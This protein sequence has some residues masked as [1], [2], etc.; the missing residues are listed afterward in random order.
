DPSVEL[1]TTADELAAASGDGPLVGLFADTIFPYLLDGYGE[2]PT[3]AEMTDAALDRLA[4]D[5]D[6]FV[7]VVESARI[8][9]ASHSNLDGVHL[10]TAALDEAVARVLAREWGDRDLTVL[11]TADHECGGLTVGDAGEPS[12]RLGDHTNAD[13][14]VFGW[15]DRAAA[16]AGE[17]VDNLW[18]HAVLAAAID[19]TDVVAPD[20][21]RLADGELSDLGE[22]VVAQVHASSFGAGHHQLD[23]LRVAADA[24]GLWVGVDGVF[25]DHA[26]AVIAWI[27]LD[28]GAGTGVGADLVLADADGRA[29][30]MLSTFVPSPALDGLGFDA[31]LIDVST[32]DVRADELYD[33]AGLRL[34]HPPHGSEGDLWWMAAVVTFD[35]GNVAYGDA[36]AP[37]AGPTGETAGGMEAWVPWASLAPDGLPAEGTTI[38]VFVVMT[39]TTGDLVSNQA[40]PPFADAAAP[41]RDAI[42]VASVVL[43]EVDAAGLAVGAPALAP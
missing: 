30:T 20:V 3:L 10:E 8:D 1:V 40:L 18:I 25:D 35:D 28:W 14:P 9:H 2:E 6:G 32:T 31:A 4:G 26:D 34:F 42:P 43:L 13:V 39:D 16:L 37:D 19:G 38:A 12:W 24:D 23:A 21:P 29:D 11:V 33:E 22:P 5:P 7:L 41:A 36:D 17:R 27:D 15:G